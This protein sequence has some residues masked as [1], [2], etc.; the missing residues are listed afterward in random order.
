MRKIEFPPAILALDPS[1]NCTGYS[2]FVGGELK[3]CGVIHFRPK[4]LKGHHK[5]TTGEKL[6]IIEKRV[7]E[8]IDQYDVKLAVMEKYMLLFKQGKKKINTSAETAKLLPMVRGVLVKTF[9]EKGIPH[10]NIPFNTV[11]KIIGGVHTADKK[12]LRDRVNKMYNLQLKTEKDTNISDAISVGYSFFRIYDLKIHLHPVDNFVEDAVDFF[13]KYYS[14]KSQTQKA[15]RLIG[16]DIN[17]W[18]AL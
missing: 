4:P 14:I 12:V 9:F 1:L 6:A 10:L 18:K 11:K 3:D 2:V 17:K 16:V 5:E 13:D 8:L 7:K 15:L